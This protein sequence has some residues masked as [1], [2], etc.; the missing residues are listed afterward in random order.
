VATGRSNQLT[1]QLGE[2]LVAAEVCR[3]SFIATTFSGNV[4]HH[5]IIASNSS[6]SGVSPFLTVAGPTKREAGC[7]GYQAFQSVREQGEFYIHSRWRDK[8]AFE[9]HAALPHT[10]RFIGTVEALVDEPL[11]ASLTEPLK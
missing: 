6:G 10:V 9:L 1:K 4:S 5:D 8:A 2:Y 7:L 3:P 11:S